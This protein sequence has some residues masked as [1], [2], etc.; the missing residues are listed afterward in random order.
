M[1]TCTFFGHRD[2][3]ESIKPLLSREIERLICEKGVT[4]FLVGDSGSFD[5]LVRRVLME[6]ENR[7]AIRYSVVLAYLPDEKKEPTFDAAHHILPDGFE[8]VPPRFAIDHRNRYMLK[9]CDFVISYITHDFGTGAAKYAGIAEKRN[10]SVINIA[11]CGQ[12]P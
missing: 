6:I 9:R 11:V 10:K 1:Y 5:Y 3:P 12:I 2:C 8:K 4:D 7:Y